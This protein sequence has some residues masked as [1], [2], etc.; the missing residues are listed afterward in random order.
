[1]QRPKVSIVTV[2]LNSQETIEESIQSVISQDYPNIEFLIIDGGSTDSTLAIIEKYK[3]KISFLVSERD[4]GIYEA[5]NKGIENSTGDIVCLL[6]SDD[7]YTK[8]N[9]ISEI[10]DIFNTNDVQAILGDV[11]YV[12]KENNAKKLRFYRSNRFTPNSLRRGFIPAHPALFLKK[13]VYE[14][15]GLFNQSYKIAGDFEFIARI[16][17][18]SK[19]TFTYIPKV[20]VKMKTGGV[21]TKLSNIF[22]VNYEILRACKANGIKTNLFL[23]ISRYPSKILDRTLCSFGTR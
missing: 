1:M 19:L 16:F 18:D 15:Y 6:H 17:S 14:K 22:L 23:L 4:S 13:S 10:V 9:I 8:N 12:S 3:S 7:I 5:L 11:E 21:S 20:F 2:T